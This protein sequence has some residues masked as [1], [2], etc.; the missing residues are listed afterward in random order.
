MKYRK[1]TTGMSIGSIENIGRKH[2]EWQKRVKQT[3]LSVTI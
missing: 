2:R 1:G 3:V